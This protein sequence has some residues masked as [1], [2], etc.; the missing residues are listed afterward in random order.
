MSKATGWTHAHYDECDRA[1]TDPEAVDSPDLPLKLAE[2]CSSLS[3]PPCILCEFTQERQ[4]VLVQIFRTSSKSVCSARVVA[5][6]VCCNLEAKEVL[7]LAVVIVNMTIHNRG[8][9]MR[10]DKV[11]SIQR[12]AINLFLFSDKGEG[13]IFFR[14]Q[15]SARLPNTVIFNHAEYLH[16][17]KKYLKNV[18]SKSRIEFV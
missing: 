5:F 8:F 4:N 17:Q 15:Y 18:A 7:R 10:F 12:N 3:P 11:D 14:N 1:L 2:P 6:G 13:Y 16:I 9:K